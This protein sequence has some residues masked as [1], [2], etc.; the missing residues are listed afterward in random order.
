[1]DYAL[2]MAGGSGTRLWPLSRQNT[3]KQA[4]RLVG[5]RSMFQHAV[6]R[7]APDF[8]VERIFVVTRGEHATLLQQQAPELP[9]ENFIIEPEGRGTAPAI[10]LAA[11]HLSRRD[12]QAVMVVLTAD[13]FI[14]E[15]ER[16]R[17][18][19]RAASQV[20]R[21]GQ[22]VTLGIQPPSPSTG[23]G[24]IHQGQPLGE[25]GGFAVFAVERFVEKPALEAARQM[26]ASGEYSW[27]SGMFIWQV[28]RILNEFQR[29]MPA[30]YAQLC[31]VAET[32]GT[33]AYDRVLGRVWPQVV[34]Q[35]I[36]Y[37]IMEGA[38]DVAVLPVE[39][40][41]SDVG[42]WESLFDL[43]PVDA[44]GNAVAG[45]FLGIDTHN[46]LVFGGPRLVA[47][48]GVEGLVIVDTGDALLVCPRAREQEVRELV[49][50]LKESGK[51][52]WL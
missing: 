30:F 31:V 21:Q 7:L 18:A 47:T 5:E 13:H 25:V 51:G 49:G 29:Q 8:P 9:V 19:L 52:Q 39:I 1:M 4:L 32:L 36:D 45:E 10:G 14:S 22:L 28:Q 17:R 15:T 42:S 41:W 33:P 44:Q 40:G 11:I 6:D 27:N 38:G 46:T 24:Y 20:A 37:G 12:S 23:F 48:I 35:T 2:I 43:L 50:R 34:K 26:V 16:F 3:P